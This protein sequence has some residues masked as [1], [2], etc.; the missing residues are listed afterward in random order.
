ML[1]LG[2]TT[3]EACRERLRCNNCDSTGAIRSRVRARALRPSLRRRFF[4][5]L[6]RLLCERRS[7]WRLRCFLCSARS[8]RLAASE[9]A[10]TAAAAA[11][12]AAAIAPLI[13]SCTTTASVSEATTAWERPG[14]Q[15]TGVCKAVIL[16]GLRA[17]S[18]IGTT[19]LGLGFGIGLESEV[20]SRKEQE[21]C[22]CIV[23]LQLWAECVRG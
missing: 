10:A 18:S 2:S 21:G 1:N 23:R 4:R 13:N 19:H 3:S 6:V 16:S 20:A 17:G 5:V 14:C 9:S 7:R 15:L 12:S 8:F 22:S 11:T